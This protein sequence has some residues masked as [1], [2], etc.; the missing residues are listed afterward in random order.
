M[1]YFLDQNS[2]GTTYFKKKAE[3]CSNAGEIWRSSLVKLW[4]VPGVREVSRRLWTVAYLPNAVTY[5]DQLS[6]GLTWALPLQELERLPNK[7]N[8]LQK[9][10]TS[11]IFSS[12]S[13]FNSRISQF[14]RLFITTA[15]IHDDP[16]FAL[17]RQEV[18]GMAANTQPQGAFLSRPSSSHQPNQHPNDPKKRTFTLDDARYEDPR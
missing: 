1:Y 8:D 12:R 17:L 9:T 11:A 15:L 4:R 6:H 10:P 16:L 18:F 2:N 3:G 5:F 13:T 7:A 14:T